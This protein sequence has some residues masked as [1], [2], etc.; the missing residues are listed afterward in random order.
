MTKYIL[1][2]PV[3]DEEDY[4]ERTI[5]SVIC[6][7]I[8]PVQWII[9]ND[10]SHDSTGEIIDRYAQ[11]YPWITARHRN[12]RGFRNSA[13]GEIDAF[14]DG[15]S[16][17]ACPDWEF[18]VK[19]DG[20]LSFSPDYFALCFSEFKKNPRLGIGGGGIYHDLDGQIKLEE[21]PIFHVRGATK[22][23]RREC[24]DDIGD[25]M[26]APGWDTVDELKA[27]MLGWTTRSFPQLRL[28]HYRYTG[29]AEGAWKNGIKDGRANYIAGYHPLFMFL[30]CG[31][32]LLK[33][34]RLVGSVA[35]M[36]GFLSGYWRRTPRVQDH[37]LI[38]YTRKQ[39]MRRILLL[40]TIWK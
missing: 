40:D 21:A 6:Q 3:R 36:L 13:G 24:W 1:I 15:F 5:L 30:K 26:R 10:G 7:R 27:N 31:G 33:C 38:R 17:I 29:A 28:L 23:Y 32:R 37:K 11:Q 39:Q 25:L 18:I 20:D 34:P 8:R 22:I 35:L 16:R 19:L 9:V 4:L 2:T 14:Y 12:D